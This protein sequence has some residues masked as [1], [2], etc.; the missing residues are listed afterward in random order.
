MNSAKRN[1]FYH[2]SPKRFRKGQIIGTTTGNLFMT[3]AP[4][5]HYSIA[6]EAVNENW[7]VYEVV[8]IGKLGWGRTFDEWIADAAEVV[9]KVGTARGLSRNGKRE[10]K[11]HRPHF[12]RHQERILIEAPPA[13][14][15]VA[16]R[17]A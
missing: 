8:P 14:R 4:A 6:P 12:D 5:P 2:A 15:P 7:T 17:I 1:R 9:R 16:E 11:G 3:N 13:G 10:S